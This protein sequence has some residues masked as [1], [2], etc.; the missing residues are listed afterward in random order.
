MRCSPELRGKTIVIEYNALIQ[1][2]KR[3]DFV[4]CNVSGAEEF[5]RV[6]G[7]GSTYEEGNVDDAVAVIGRVIDSLDRMAAQ[8]K[9]FVNNSSNK[10]YPE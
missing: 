3:Q 8:G 7:D 1:R 9:L 10:E 2:I 5:I 6:R 4:A